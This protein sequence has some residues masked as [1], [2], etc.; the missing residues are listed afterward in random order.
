M[1]SACGKVIKMKKV[2]FI[3]LGNIGKGIC[4]N[5]I[6]NGFELT[7]YDVYRPAM[8]RFEGKA[9]L[10]ADPAE[11]I[12]NAEAV[13]LSLPKS[14]VVEDT[15]ATFIAEG[16]EGKLIIDTSTSYPLST[17]KLYADVKAHGGDLLD[18]P[19][20]AGPDEAEAGTLEILVAGDK[21]A[22]DRAEELFKAYC[23]VYKFVGE[24][25]TAHL[26]KIAQ[27]FVGLTEALIFAQLFPVIDKVGYPPEKLAE[28]I[29]ESV[30]A[31]WTSNFYN[32]KYVSR[33]YHLDFALKLGT[34]DLSYMKRIYEEFNVP[35]FIL[36]GALDLCRVSLGDQKEGEPPIDFSYPCET[37]YRLLEK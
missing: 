30:L 35:G 3:G 18:A 32:K 8:E 2:G 4:K 34:K 22:Y 20:M 6:K 31:N 29:G 21:E 37:M 33:D 15:I 10:A 9:K 1:Q 36:D 16:I 13:F 7:V 12:N 5:L 27:N 25:G 11:V 28:V 24:S 19:L 14:E 23:S 26:L 17:K